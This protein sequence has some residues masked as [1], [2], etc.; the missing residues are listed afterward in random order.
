MMHSFIL[1]PALRL[2]FLIS[3]GEFACISLIYSMISHKVIGADG[4]KY[5]AG[6]M[7]VCYR[8]LWMYTPVIEGTRIKC[9]FMLT[10]L[11]IDRKHDTLEYIE[12]EKQKLSPLTILVHQILAPLLI[13]WTRIVELQSMPEK[14]FAVMGGATGLV[15]SYFGISLNV[16]FFYFIVVFVEVGGIA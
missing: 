11:I 15:G 16:I 6:S 7:E 1:A 4:R 3:L 9:L 12:V 5:M 13:A 10:G 2:I 14:Q 8:E